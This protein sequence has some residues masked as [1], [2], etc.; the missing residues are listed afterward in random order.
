MRAAF[1]SALQSC[2]ELQ[3]SDAMTRYVIAEAGT[4]ITSRL[5]P[6][7]SFRTGNLSRTIS[8]SLVRFKSLSSPKCLF[9]LHV[10]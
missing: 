8:F 6:I 10:S 9:W 4:S 2:D 1:A 7:S 3:H 5:N